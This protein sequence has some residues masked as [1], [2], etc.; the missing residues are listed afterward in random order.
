MLKVAGCT[1]VQMGVQSMDDD[2]KTSALRRNE[3]SSHI[4]HSLKV[5][6]NAG[7][8]IKVDHMFGLPGENNHAQET[9]RELYALHCPDRIQTFWTCFLPGTQMLK[10][11]LESGIVTPEEAERLNEGIDFYFFRNADNIKNPEMVKI[12]Q[13]YEFLFKA[14]PLLP[15]SIRIRFKEKH[16]RWIPALAKKLI[17]TGLDVL[18]AIKQRN[19]DF[20]AYA[21]F[22]L[23]HLSKFIIRKLGIRKKMKAT[24][25]EKQDYWNDDNP[26]TPDLP[27]H[28][29]PISKTMQ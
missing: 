15:K 25:P 10:Q 23:F 4:Q 5:M 17:G 8:K 2:F 14:F 29:K 26:G 18:N 22:Y 28:T 3:K 9:A 1:W 27:M 19:P 16:V 24:T 13:G 11:G 6:I 7:L 21:K 20:K 12:Y